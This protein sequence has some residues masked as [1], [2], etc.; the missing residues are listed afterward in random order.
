MKT[1]TYFIRLGRKIITKSSAVS[2]VI[3]YANCDGVWRF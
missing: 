3:I 1:V 2:V